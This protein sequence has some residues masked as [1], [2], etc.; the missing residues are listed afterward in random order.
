MNLCLAQVFLYVILG[1]KGPESEMEAEGGFFAFYKLTLDFVENIFPYLFFIFVIWLFRKPIGSFI[2]RIG[3]LMFDWNKKKVDIEVAPEFSAGLDKGDNHSPTEAD[4]PEILSDVVGVNPKEEW[5]DA[6]KPLLDDGELEKATD[7][8]EEYYAK[9]PV[10]DRV[11][12]R[13]L[14]LYFLYTKNKDASILTQLDIIICSDISEDDRLHLSAI[15]LDLLHRISDY[16]GV[17]AF[18]ERVSSMF[19]SL[20]SLCILAVSRS[21]AFIAMGDL[22]SARSALLEK[23]RLD[24]IDK[25][26]LARLYAAMSEVEK[27]DK[28]LLLHVL[29]LNMAAHL[30]PGNES[31]LFDAAYE[32][33]ELLLNGLSINNYLL[34][35]KMATDNDMCFNNL[36]VCAAECDVSVIAD[37]YFSKAV[38]AENTLASANVGER[39]LKGGNYIAAQRLI[40]DALNSD[41]EISPNVHAV[42]SKIENKISQDEER[43]NDL[44]DKAGEHSRHC[45]KYVS[46]Y[47]SDRG[48]GGSKIRSTGKVITSQDLNDVVVKLEWEGV[49]DKGKCGLYGVVHG[50]SVDFQY[51]QRVGEVRTATTTLLG[52]GG[53][54][55]IRCLAYV[56]DGELIIFPYDFKKDVNIVFE[57]VKS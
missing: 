42:M 10:G 38:D 34:L 49:V 17:V 25:K 54:E 41:G 2:S 22:S 57:I 37:R 52:F 56:E 21:R 33:G 13:G 8:F 14:F 28:N 50:L 40:K 23:I 30:D 46:A 15:L 35:E 48:F 43:W 39:L 45:L 47:Y 12:E 24:S 36:A 4:K 32:A 11:F 44:I 7:K 29:C 1:E 6:I 55:M 26:T 20:D 18:I 19:S 9:M 51:K 53:D 27:S 31:R 16:D 3:K 5:Y